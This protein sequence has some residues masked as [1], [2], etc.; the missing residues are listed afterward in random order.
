MLSAKDFETYIEVMIM[1][2]I[3]LNARIMITMVLVMMTVNELEIFL[4]YYQIIFSTFSWMLK[5]TPIIIMLKSGLFFRP[6]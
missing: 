2:M 4:Y 3:M 6:V 5:F 1:V